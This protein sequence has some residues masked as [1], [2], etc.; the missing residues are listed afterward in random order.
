MQL[1]L[2]GWACCAAPVCADEVGAPATL[3]A[4]VVTGKKIQEAVPDAEVK[5]R[6][7]TAMRTDQ[8]FYD[9]HVTVTIKDGVV[10]LHG[11]VFDDWDL[12]TAR[13]IAKRIPGVKRVIN[14]LEMQLGGE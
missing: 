6:V 11:I 3:D 10:T 5:Q 14:D 13:R 7:E 8:F 2:L 4:I 9:D 1:T 12:R